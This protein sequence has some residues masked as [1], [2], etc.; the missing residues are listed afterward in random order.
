ML[1]KTMWQMSSKLL[2]WLGTQGRPKT[3]NTKPLGEIHQSEPE[4]QHAK[5]P[6]VPKSCRR[7]SDPSAHTRILKNNTRK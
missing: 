7:A 1:N 3:Q 5:S 4:K 2:C 6:K